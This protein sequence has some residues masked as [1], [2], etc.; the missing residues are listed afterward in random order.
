MLTAV[1]PTT[2]W[3]MLVNLTLGVGASAGSTAPPV[4]VDGM[5]IGPK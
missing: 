3:G 4:V 5:T 2:V 1:T